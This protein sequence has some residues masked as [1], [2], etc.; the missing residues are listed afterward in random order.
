MEEGGHELGTP[1]RTGWVGVSGSSGVPSDTWCGSEL[2]A[3]CSWALF[4]LAFFFLL[5]FFF[6]DEAARGRGEAPH[7]QDTFILHL[8]ASDWIDCRGAGAART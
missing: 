8:R 3:A 5:F 6:L 7:H 4:L 1:I 2:L